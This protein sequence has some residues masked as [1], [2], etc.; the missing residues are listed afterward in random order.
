MDYVASMDACVAG[1]VDAVTMTNGDALVTG[2]TGKP[3]VGII[4]INLKR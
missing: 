4:I 2:G 1:T 3:S